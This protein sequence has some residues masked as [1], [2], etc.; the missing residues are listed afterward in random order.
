VYKKKTNKRA[1]NNVFIFLLSLLY[2]LTRGAENGLYVYGHIAQCRVE[3]KLASIRRFRVYSLF[4]LQTVE[5]D[6][7]FP[8][9][10]RLHWHIYWLSIIFPH[11]NTDRNQVRWVWRP[12]NW[13]LT[14]AT[15]RASRIIFGRSLTHFIAVMWWSTVVLKQHLKTRTEWYIFQ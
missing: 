5:F 10:Y 7:T 6:A 11:L 15:N 8:V 2:C 13:S 12:G 4:H 3:K 14:L 1:I 9:W